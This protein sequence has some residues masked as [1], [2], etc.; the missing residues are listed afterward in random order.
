MQQSFDEN[1][2]TSNGVK[3][4]EFVVGKPIQ[5]IEQSIDPTQPEIL[6]KFQLFNA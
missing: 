1:A 6:V 2:S 3:I 4:A 5:P